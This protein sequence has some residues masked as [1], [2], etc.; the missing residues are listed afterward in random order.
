V[1]LIKNAA[2]AVAEVYGDKP[3][4]LVQVEAGKGASYTWVRVTDNGPGIPEDKHR[5]IF[6]PFY[7]TKPPGKGTGLGLN[8]VWRIVTRFR[9][10]ITVQSAVGKGTTFE[11]RF[12]DENK[13]A[14]S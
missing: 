2:E 10:S 13:S 11:L 8:I 12:N 7:T 9:G 3:G 6:D 4:G 5:M 14:L 1:N